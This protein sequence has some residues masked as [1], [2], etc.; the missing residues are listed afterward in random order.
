[1]RVAMTVVL[2]HAVGSIVVR[3]YVCGN[4]AESTG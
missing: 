1:M 3:L 4:A 2:L